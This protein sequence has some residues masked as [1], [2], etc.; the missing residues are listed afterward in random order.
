MK[1]VLLLN[2]PG[3][4]KGSGVPRM[5][6]L[7][8]L[9]LLVIQ[10]SAQDLVKGKVADEN[11]SGMPGV[12][13]IVKGTTN[14]TT[15]DG[16]G[17]YSLSAGSDATLVF[18]FIGY[19]TQE[20]QVNGRTAIDVALAPSV[21]ALNEVVV[22][23]YGTQ[24]KRDITGA[25][26]KVESNVLL[27]TASPN[28]IDQLKGHA[29]GVNI[30]T[31]SA[32]PGGAS[33]IRIRGNRTMVAS[34]MLSGNSAS[35][36]AATA[37]QADAPLLVVDGIP[38]SGNLNDISSNDIASME[39]LKDASATAIYGSRG[40]GGVILITTKR[41]TEGKVVFTYD[42]YYGVSKV[43]DE[44]RVFNGPEYAQF[45]ADAAAGNSTAPNTT[46]YG[47]SPAEQAALA[48]GISTNWQ[49][50]IYQNAPITNHSLGVAGGSDKSKYSLSAGYFKQG[51]I[52]PNQDFTRYTI[53]SSMDHQL[54]KRIRLGLTTINAVTY[55]NLPGGSGVT[56]GLMRMTPLASPYNDDGTVNLLPQVGQID[57]QSINPLTLE[58]KSDAILSRNRRLRTFNSFYGEVDIIK[59]L[60]YRANIGLDY[61][62]DKSD[63]YSGP[64]T[65]VNTSLLQSQSTASVR[66]TENYQYTVEN[67]LFYDKTFNDKHKLGLTALYSFQ[68]THSQGSGLFGIGVPFD[69]VHNTNLYLAATVSAANPQNAADNPNF[70]WERGL[71][72]YMGRVTY[73]YDGRY[74]L[75]ATVRTDG[76]SVLSPGNQYYTYPAFAGAWNLSNEKFMESLA[77]VSNLKLRAGWGV[78]ASQ[79]INPYSTLGGLGTS[80]YNFG[81]GTAGQQGGYTVSN[82]PNNSLKWQSTSQYNVGIDFGILENRISGA[83]E[84]YGQETSDILLPVSLPPS[85]GAGSTF[86]NVGKTKGRGV[87]I[88]LNTVNVKTNS[89]LTW[90]TDL[91]YFFNREEIVQLAAPGQA[92]D[93]GNGWFVGQPIAV[94][95]D[96][97]KI[98]IW[99]T[100]DPGLAAQ[101]SPVQRAGQIRV[102]DW[103]TANAV[104]GA[105]DYGVPDGRITPDDRMI[106]GN[107]QPKFEAGMTNRVAFKNFDL[108]ISVYAR[109]GMKIVVP[110]L[111]SE[112]GGANFT[113]YNFFMQSRQNQLKVDY[114]TPTNPT[115]AFPQPDA[116]LGAPLYSSTLSYVDG[117]FI[118]CRTINLGYNVPST[119]LEKA[120]ITSLR[121]YVSAV[122]PF[123]IWSPFVQD[124]YGPDPEGNG[125]GGGVNASGTS[126][127]GTV[128]RQITVNANNPATRQFLFGLNLKF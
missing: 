122:N 78:T 11:G 91:N 73:S 117:S 60:K 49:K 9:M 114:W 10:V 3:L 59:G 32:V 96:Y 75:T 121:V 77:F 64:A 8:S 63:G 95:Y 92:N 65:Y 128:G 19:A 102:L 6:L 90:T 126:N 35:T 119:L 58:T 67:L 44:L 56:N 94:L 101:T 54:S 72:S 118:K 48:S 16:N 4:W 103:N 74:S 22:V 66:N 62:Q 69:Y 51:G 89:G 113:G 40:A 79:G 106:I 124:G 80:A 30:V 111:A 17:N 47:L 31:A 85:N 125:Y 84:V 109:M 86:L 18:S 37:D 33:Q 93:I 46:A 115:N 100:D 104:P 28:A 55:Q 107:F 24:A 120:G 112:P 82:L 26:T 13:I 83:V 43:M 88:T 12:N 7:F 123:V 81:Q 105:A 110:Y 1:E 2:F 39:I 25:I 70:F 34:S 68:K 99:Q 14:G 108:S 41:G 21:E 116:S 15:T 38:Y 23:G 29:A 98:G 5:M 71:I 53:R 52:I 45:K 27:Q 20:I 76:A 97:K 36:D 57:G 87:E 127:A 50:L 61:W 42:A